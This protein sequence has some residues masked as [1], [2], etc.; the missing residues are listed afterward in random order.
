MMKG[1]RKQGPP[2]GIGVKS[3][4]LLHKNFY[5]DFSWKSLLKDLAMRI[6]AATAAVG[7]FVFLAF[8]GDFFDIQLLQSAGGVL[9]VILI[10][11]PV[12]FITAAGIHYSRK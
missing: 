12:V 11:G 3:K 6:G 9:T 2:C 8:L 1:I 5:I 7:V 4:K 10:T